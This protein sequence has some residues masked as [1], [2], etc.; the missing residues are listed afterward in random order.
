MFI[1]SLI[2]IVTGIFGGIFFTFICIASIL[3]GVSGLLALSDENRVFFVRLSKIIGIV[4]AVFALL[5]PFRDVSFVATI[6]AFW[7][8]LQLFDCFKVFKLVQYVAN[9]VASIVFWIRFYIK[10]QTS[11]F[12]QVCG[13]ISIF[14]IIPIVLK[15]VQ[16][17]GS[18]ENLGGNNGNNL[19]IRKVLNKLSSWIKRTVPTK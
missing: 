5:L 7:W 1:D 9:I 8:T 15:M 18:T 19:P 2:N 17:S 4:I 10:D 13:D 16:L 12:L 3:C 14:V 11:L 6:L